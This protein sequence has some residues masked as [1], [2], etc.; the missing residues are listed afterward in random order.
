MFPGDNI[1]QHSMGWTWLLETPLFLNMVPGSVAASI[2]YP[3]LAA[4][5][6]SLSTPR[7]S[8]TDRCWAARQMNL[9][10]LSSL[11]PPPSFPLLLHL[12]FFYLFSPSSSLPP[13]S[14]HP[15]YSS[16][17][18]WSVKIATSLCPSN[19]GDARPPWQTLR[20]TCSAD[21]VNFL[22]LS[23]IWQQDWN[24]SLIQW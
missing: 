2:I 9:Y 18:R 13:F 21:L 23:R 4:G 10:F 16:W 20:S 8:R 24:W 3:D 22:L 7:T 17:E 14:S 12:F 5:C 1:W 15:Q 6:N 11:L 19:W